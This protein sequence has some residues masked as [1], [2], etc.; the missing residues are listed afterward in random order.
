MLFCITSL[1]YRIILRPPPVLSRVSSDKVTGI[2]CLKVT[3]RDQVT[4]SQQ[5]KTYGNNSIGNDF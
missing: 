3:M 2:F 4:S 1:N 5:Q